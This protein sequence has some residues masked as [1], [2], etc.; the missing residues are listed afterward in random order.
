MDEATSSIFLLSTRDGTSS[1]PHCSVHVC[2]S[3]HESVCFCRKTPG[4]ETRLFLG[5]SR[6]Y[7]THVQVRRGSKEER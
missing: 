1:A 6:L 4:R 7:E 3:L 5:K 2:I